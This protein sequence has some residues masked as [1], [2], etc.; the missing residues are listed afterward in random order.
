MKYEAL[1]ITSYIRKLIESINV[2][3]GIQVF[4][5]IFVLLLF[6]I[7]MAYSFIS[8]SGISIFPTVRL[9]II[10]IYVHIILV[11][12]SYYGSATHNEV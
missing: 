6:G 3:F 10:L 2:A 9:I 4:C 5:T 8:T 1:K 12:I 11:E 7:I